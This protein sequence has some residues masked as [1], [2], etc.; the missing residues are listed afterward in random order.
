M[1]EDVASIMHREFLSLDTQMPI[2]QAAG[3][4]HSSEHDAAPVVDD[5]GALVGILTQ[6]DC[7]GP[8]MEASYYQQWRGTVGDRMSSPVKT[9]EAETG[10]VAAAQMFLSEPHRAFPVLQ[11]GRLVGMLYRRDLLGALLRLG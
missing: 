2:R 1:T 8:A 6:K 5:A 4:L 3:L 10:F 9:I 7:F 11:S